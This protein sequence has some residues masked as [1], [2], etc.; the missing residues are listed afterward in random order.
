MMGSKQYFNI[1][2]LGAKNAQELARV[3]SGKLWSEINQSRVS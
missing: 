3:L 1:S 2:A